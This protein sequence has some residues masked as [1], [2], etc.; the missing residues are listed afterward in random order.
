MKYYLLT[1]ILLPCSICH[2]EPHVIPPRHGAFSLACP[3]VGKHSQAILTHK[4]PL[5]GSEHVYIDSES[6]LNASLSP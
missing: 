5:A 6:V 2:P 1:N 4:N 3:Q